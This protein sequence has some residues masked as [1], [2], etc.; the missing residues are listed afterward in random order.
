MPLYKVKLSQGKRSIIESIEAKSLPHLLDFY[1]Y[2]T[3]ME[4]REVSKIE[5]LNPSDVI[6]DD[7]FNYDSL[8]KVVAK[9]DS[10]RKSKQFIFHNLKKT[11][12]DQEVFNKM[13]ECLEVS[14]THIDSLFASLR[15]L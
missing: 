6:P 9:S 13:I 7:D 11:R 5:Y 15:K 4:V 10:L 14:G 1:S 12:S 3:T 2:I 8:M